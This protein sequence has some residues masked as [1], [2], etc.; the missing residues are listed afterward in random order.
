MQRHNW[1]Q[2]IALTLVLTV[3]IGAVSNLPVF[4]QLPKSPKVKLLNANTLNFAAGVYTW[5]SWYAA[6]ANGTKITGMYCTN[7]DVAAHNIVWSVARGGV[8]YFIGQQT[9][10]ANGLA[11]GQPGL[12]QPLLSTGFIPNVALDSDA[13]P[14]IILESGDTLQIAVDVRLV[15]TTELSITCTATAVDF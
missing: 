3:G 9:L 4:P 7:N 11:I 10:A 15:A 12:A 2:V 1:W 8:A 14:M 5:A 13:N 6:G